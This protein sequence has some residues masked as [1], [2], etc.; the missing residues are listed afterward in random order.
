VR[1]KQLGVLELLKGRP[2][3]EVSDVMMT[4]HILS[5][6]RPTQNNT[7]D[8]IITLQ[9]CQHAAKR[10]HFFIQSAKRRNNPN[11]KNK[12]SAPL[13]ACSFPQK[14]YRLLMQQ[15]D[16]KKVYKI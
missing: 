5:K 16:R 14:W 2:A 11:D 13:H 10:H 4:N 3:V 12:P 1:V 15:K 8:A 9:S 7:A 6:R